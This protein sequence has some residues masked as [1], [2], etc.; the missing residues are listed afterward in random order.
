MKDKYI[1]GL[2]SAYHESSACIIKNGEMIAFSE[3]ERFNRVKHGKPAL[4]NNSDNL[5]M[6]SI[7][8]YLAKKKIKL[9]DVSYIAYNFNPEKRLAF[10]KN[11]QHP[12]EIMDGDFG[13]KKGEALFYKTNIN[14]EKKLRKLGFAGEFFYLNHHD[15]HAAGAYYSS[16]F[17][18]SA[19]LIVDGIGE[20]ESTSFYDVK[21]GK[22]EKITEIE[23]KSAR[24][25]AEGNII[26]WFQGAMEVGPRALGH[27]SILGDPRNPDMLKTINKK[28]KFREE[29][30]PL[31]PSVLEEDASNWFQLGNNL[32][33][34]GKYMLATFNANSKKKKLTPA[35]V[36]IDGTS[37]IQMVSKK[38]SPKYHKL[39]SE[40][41][42][43][44]G[45][46]ILLNTS[47]NIQEPIV[48]SPQDAID[49]FKRSKIDYLVMESYLVKK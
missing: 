26:A 43:L 42:K 23:K 28:V 20:H 32:P 35:V 5:P 46:P 30:R 24:L 18:N 16:G 37:R 33:D 34:A 22:F 19:V 10:H 27:R 15:C 6:E 13:T 31:C 47:F 25:L 7:N 38:Y 9:S 49:T 21:N 1:L 17:K 44:T 11:Y 48:C 4:I 45:V 29:F 14:V 41:K 8:Y 12:Y 2:N 3:E 39:I 36:H 40:F